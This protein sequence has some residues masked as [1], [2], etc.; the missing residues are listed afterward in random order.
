MVSDGHDLWLE[1]VDAAGKKYLFSF[2]QNTSDSLLNIREQRW[3]VDGKGRMV[4][5]ASNKLLAL[6]QR[7]GGQVEMKSFREADREVDLV[8]PA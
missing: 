1:E 6:V 2:P 5:K 8:L 4:H 3:R 7:H